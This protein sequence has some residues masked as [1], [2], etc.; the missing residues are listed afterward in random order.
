MNPTRRKFLAQSAAAS[1]IVWAAPV[2]STITSPAGAASLAVAIVTEGAIVMIPPPPLVPAVPPSNTV[3]YGW[4]EECLTLPS[5]LAVDSDGRD[6]LYKGNSPVGP[7][8]IATGTFVCS[9]FFRFDSASG[10]N[11]TAEGTVRVPAGS[12]AGLAF[13][14]S[15][16]TSTGVVLG[17]SGTT[18]GAYDGLTPN[19]QVIVTT[20]GGE[21][22][23]QIRM[24]AN[25]RQNDIDGIRVI[26]SP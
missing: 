23:I 10:G 3:I 5:N 6:G 4:P 16:L 1:G 2:L 13:H 25:A 24:M 26:L 22:V 20:T 7:Y 12:L 15:T 14:T 9:Y 21:T 19:D 17:A 11:S 18:Y 8:T